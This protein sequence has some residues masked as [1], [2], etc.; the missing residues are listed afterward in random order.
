[1][2]ERFECVPL[3]SDSNHLDMIRDFVIDREQEYAHIPD[4]IIGLEAYLKRAAWQEDLDEQVKIYL[5]KD[6]IVGE[7]AA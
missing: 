3:T 7:V 5:V 6:V 2:T 4:Q 1:M